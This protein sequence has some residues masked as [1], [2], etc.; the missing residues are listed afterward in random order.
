MLFFLKHQGT[1]PELSTVRSAQVAV[2]SA[3]LTSSSC[4]NNVLALVKIRFC[5]LIDE[6]FK[7]ND[8]LYI[9]SDLCQDSEFSLF[10]ES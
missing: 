4:T 1:D 7:H 9:R 5:P 3:C 8:V 6:P 2:Q 10:L